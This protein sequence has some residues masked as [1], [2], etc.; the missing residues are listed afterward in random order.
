MAFIRRKGNAYYLVHSVRRGGKVRQLHLARLGDR[1]QITPEV[2]RQVRRRHPLL[3]L[4]WDR[5]RRQVSRQIILWP[6]DAEA[7]DKLKRQVHGL[8]RALADLAPAWLALAAGEARSR[9]LASLFR[10]LHTTLDIKLQQFDRLLA[11]RPTW[12]V[13]ARRRLVP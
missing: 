5:V 10:L 13:M 1:P 3:E 4:D 11:G 8:T 6:T 2:I 7:I 12:P 9:E